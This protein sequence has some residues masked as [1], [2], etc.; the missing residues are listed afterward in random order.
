MKY[1]ET[2]QP[3]QSPHGT[4]EPISVRKDSRA[5]ESQSAKAPAATGGVISGL[6]TGAMMTETLVCQDYPS[7]LD[8]H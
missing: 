6:D 4:S 2:Q 7:G 8:S 3:T 5:R 1:E